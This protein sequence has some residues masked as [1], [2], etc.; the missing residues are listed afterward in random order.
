M[1]YRTRQNGA[2][3]RVELEYPPDLISQKFRV[4]EQ[5]LLQWLFGF[6]G[7]NAN[8]QQ[9]E[10][11]AFCLWL[12]ADPFAYQ[13]PHES[14]VGVHIFFFQLVYHPLQQPFGSPIADDLEE[15]FSFPVLPRRNEVPESYALSFRRGRHGKQSEL[16]PYD[17]EISLVKE[18]PDAFWY[19]FL[20]QSH[21][22]LRQLPALGFRKRTESGDHGAGWDHR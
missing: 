10:N 12:G 7:V 13:P 20:S 3:R 6:E 9:L 18:R 21:N 22:C 19:D 4:L 11:V 5:F 15:R 16:E 14:P 1:K 17:L 2:A 8:K